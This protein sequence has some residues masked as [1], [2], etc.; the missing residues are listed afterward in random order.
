MK[1]LKIQL[2]QNYP[3]P[4]F[5]S[6]AKVIIIQ[7]EDGNS[8]ELT[9]VKNWEWFKDGCYYIVDIRDHDKK[10]TRFASQWFKNID[11]LVKIINLLNEEVDN[12]Q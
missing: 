11:H 8:F 10:I 7:A 4:Y 5:S 12:H 9:D 3:N 6:E 2:N 1:E